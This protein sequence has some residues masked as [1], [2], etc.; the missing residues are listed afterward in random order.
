MKEQAEHTRVR[1]DGTAEERARQEKAR[2]DNLF[3]GIDSCDKSFLGEGSSECSAGYLG[4][5]LGKNGTFSD[6]STSLVVNAEHSVKAEEMDATNKENRATNER[7]DRGDVGD[8]GV[9]WDDVFQTANCLSV[10]NSLLQ[11]Q[12]PLKLDS[13]VHKISALSRA[14]QENV[15]TDTTPRVEKD[16]LTDS[17][18]IGEKGGA[19]VSGIKEEANGS[20][21]NGNSGINGDTDNRLHDGSRVSP[22]TVK[23]ENGTSDA[24]M[25]H[26]IKVESVI[27]T[28]NETYGIESNG[29]KNGMEAEGQA[30]AEVSVEVR[31]GG[32]EAEDT[33]NNIDTNVDTSAV[34]SSEECSAVSLIVPMDVEEPSAGDVT[35]EKVTER[36]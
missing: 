15:R 24:T 12:M 29:E 7:S 9:N 20:Y 32:D 3:L 11:L 28:E 16:L 34:I 19:V 31:I 33:D 14:G 22:D 13:L 2:L 10:F 17:A 18:D 21:T 4:R 27:K 26:E 6:A 36:T 5:S 25:G 1:E 8:V 35:A 30:E 23:V